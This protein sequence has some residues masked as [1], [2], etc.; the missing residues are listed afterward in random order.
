MEEETQKL[1][2][3]V[4]QKRKGRYLRSPDQSPDEIPYCTFLLG[5]EGDEENRS[6]RLVLITLLNVLLVRTQK[7]LWRE[8]IGCGIF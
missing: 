2:L 5:G 4:E 1:V 6:L 3:L 7:L 8:I